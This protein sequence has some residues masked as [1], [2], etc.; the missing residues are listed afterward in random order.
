MRHLFAKP[1]LALIMAALS[2][3][4]FGQTAPANDHAH[5]SWGAPDLQGFWTNASITHMSRPASLAT[6]VITAEQAKK[7]ESGDLNNQRLAADQKPTDQT[8][9]AP[10]TGGLQNNGNY[11]AFWWDPG[12]KVAQ[13]NGE[14]RSSWIVEPADGHIPYKTRPAGFAGGV[15]P[16]ARPAAPSPVAAPARTKPAKPLAAAKPVS[17]PAKS[18]PKAFVE[19]GPSYGAVG[20]RRENA[21]AYAGPE[22]RG[23]GERCLIGFGNT[24]GPVMNNVLYNNAY[25]IVQSPEAVM[26]L[27][28]MNHDARIIPIVADASKAA[29]A[30]KP[31]AIKPWLGDSVGWYEGDTL[32]VETRNVNP[33]QKGYI[34]D[35]GKLT[36]RFTRQSGGAL[37]YQFE[38]DDPKQFTQVWKGEMPFN[39][40]QGGLYE[41]AC[42]EGNYAMDGILE[43]ARE[44]EKRGELLE[45]TAESE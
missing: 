44:K 11:N 42:H 19:P 37:L 40:L 22:V 4:A 17:A 1:A 18:E 2:P 32:V 45:S 31:S 13:I 39:A 43:G 33:V 41:Y 6:L 9:G 35:G 36:E 16:A 12:Q 8:L 38:V 27:V 10:I 24:G 26:I 28:E 5:T 25:E 3:G 20:N 29:A 21:A 34:S 14:Y 15:A 7:L 30:H 23:V